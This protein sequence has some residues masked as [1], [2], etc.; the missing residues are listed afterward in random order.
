MDI[1]EIRKEYE[2]IDLFCSLAEIPSPSLHEEKVSA[3][4]KSICD[5][6]NIHCELDDYGNVYINIP[7]TDESKEYLLLSSHMDVIGDDSPVKTYLDDEGLIHAE[8][9]TLGADDKAGVANAL[10][11]ALWLNKSD[12]KHGGLEMVFTRDEESGMSGARHVDTSKLHSKYV[13]VLDSD[14]LG[15][16]MTS[17]ASYTLAEINLHTNKGG[18]SGNDIADTTRENA[19]KLIADLISVLPQGVFYSDEVDHHVVT[20]CNIGGIVAGNPKVTNI[21]NQDALATYSIRSSSR[22][23]EEELKSLMKFH[24]D[25][26]NAEY[27]GIAHAD[28]KFEE[29]LPPFE[30]SWDN[31]VSQ[32]FEASSNAVGVKPEIGSFHAGAETHIYAN[33]YNSKN[34]KMLPF[35]VGLADVRNMHCKEENVSYKSML[36][37]QEILRQFF[38]DFNK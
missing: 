10:Y 33:S 13:L 5:E 28:L 29:H 37:G 20:S 26:F 21:I 15:Q 2:L 8:G 30:K 16:F 38:K 6:N 18:H 12:I 22:E 17:G 11:F 3:Y 25:E 23:K 1:N 32:I 36:K 24:V 34:E 14:S 7:P 35:L 31:F 4:I 19:A 27:E 9:R